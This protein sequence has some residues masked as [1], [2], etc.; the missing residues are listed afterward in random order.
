MNSEKLARRK[1]MG[2]DPNAVSK[3]N[4]SQAGAIP[5]QPMPGM[6][7]GPGNMMNNP[8]VGQSM[9]GG[10]PQ[11]GAIDPNNP[12]SMYGDPVFQADTL[13]NTGT[14]GFAPPSGV[15]QNFVAGQVLNRNNYAP[16]P[17]NE[18]MEMMGPMALADS[19][20]RNA[21]KQYGDKEAPP[22]LIGPLGMMG[23]D[24]NMAVQAPIPGA[25]PG[26]M[27]T[28]D[29]NQLGLQGVPDTQMAA[30][31]MGM[32]TGRGGGRNQSSKGVA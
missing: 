10:A 17:F 7:Q 19:A 2:D 21:V 31:Q 26:N 25:F 32:N 5:A 28:Q 13:K 30:S 9:G 12:R 14:V 4:T 8:Q 11:P 16:Q 6:P 20:S 1:R 22:Y 29:P 27:P 24:M 15:Q 23:T 18:T 3:S